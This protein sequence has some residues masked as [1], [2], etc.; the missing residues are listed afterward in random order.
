MT[1]PKNQHRRDQ[2]EVL[3]DQ[4]QQQ[5]RK[6][7]ADVAG[8]EQPGQRLAARLRGRDGDDGSYR[9]LERDADA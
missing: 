9:G 2:R 6:R 5:D 7:H 3:H 4:P 8:E 1:A